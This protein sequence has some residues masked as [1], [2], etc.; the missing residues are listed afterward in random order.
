MLP[1]SAVNHEGI[2]HHEGHE[3]REGHFY[4][5]GFGF[6]AFGSVALHHLLFAAVL[7]IGCARVQNAPPHVDSP[8]LLI[9]DGAQRVQHTTGP[10]EVV[11]YDIQ[12]V[13][14]APHTIAEITRH[15][16]QVGWEPLKEDFLNPGISTS[17]VRGWANYQDDVRH[18]Y[19]WQWQGQWQSATGEIATYDLKYT[20]A[21]GD[22]RCAGPLHVAAFALSAEAAK[23]FRSAKP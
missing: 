19:V 4:L 12:E 2:R 20:N 5:A 6:D 3:G 21:G 9:L 18:Q 11:T 10:Q 13:C 1:L 17:L 16:E 15:L 14:P 23:A 7:A 8:A 22:T